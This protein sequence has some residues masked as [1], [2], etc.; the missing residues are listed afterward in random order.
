MSRRAALAIAAWLVPASGAAATG[1]DQA[2]AQFDQA[3]AAQVA[4]GAAP[5]MQMAVVQGDKLVCSGAYGLA[6]AGTGRKADSATRFVIGSVSKLFT[7]LAVMQLRD[8]GKLDLD[9]KVTSRLPWFTLEGDPHPSVTIRELLLQL[10]GLPREPLGASW[11][12]RRMPSRD[13]LIRDMASEPETV[14]REGAWKYSNLGYAVLGLVVEAA[15]GERYA[16]YVTAHI[17]GPLGMTDTVAEPGPATPGLALGYGAPSG[18]TRSSRDFLAMGGMLPA[19]G[20]ASTARDL[21]RLAAWMLA[22]DDG[23]VLSAASRREML[24][25]QAV[26]PDW[27]V[28]QGLGF[29][30]HRAGSAARIGH[31]G[32]AAGYAAQLQVDPSLGIGVAVL[33][34]ADD[35]HPGRLVENAFALFGAGILHERATRPVPVA[36]PAWQRYLGTYVDADGGES[37]VAIVDG[38]LAWV[39]PG[40]AEPARTA[41]FLDP[42]GAGRFRFASGGLMGETAVF[43]TDAAGRVTG[44][45]A[46][47][48]LDRKVK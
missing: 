1:L 34:N 18:G 24:R 46:G 20:I 11:T 15:S 40:A 25:A 21:G 6:D 37:G 2:C 22:T 9:D 10:G 41:I 16:D 23:P 28:G 17:L 43:E 47:G 48:T 39:E 7:A 4:G 5:A 3:V 32:R 36:D 38:R 27:A 14:P 26:L 42:A 19:A 33:A 45:R 29:E 44:L 31:A 30:L 13:Q 8:A 35:A 12:E